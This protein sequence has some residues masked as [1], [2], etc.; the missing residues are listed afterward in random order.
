VVVVMLV[1]MVV[2]VVVVKYDTMRSADHRQ[3]TSHPLACT[4]P[5][6]PTPDKT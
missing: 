5:A 1:V 4:K 2:V 6:K 3:M